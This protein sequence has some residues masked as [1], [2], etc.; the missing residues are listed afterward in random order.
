MVGVT[1]M[2]C[3]RRLKYKGIKKAKL[4][5]KYR[6]KWIYQANKWKINENKYKTIFLL[7]ENY[8]D[9]AILQTRNLYHAIWQPEA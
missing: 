1:N 9:I 7:F 8:W 2:R 3:I 5:C 4:M 6:K